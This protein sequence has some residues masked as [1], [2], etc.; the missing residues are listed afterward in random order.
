VVGIVLYERVIIALRWMA[1]EDAS[2]QRFSG[3]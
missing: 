2:A 3:G 1:Q